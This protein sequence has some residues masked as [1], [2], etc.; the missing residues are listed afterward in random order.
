MAEEV[1]FDLG[2]RAGGAHRKAAAVRQVHKDHLFRGDGI[3]FHVYHVPLGK[4]ADAAD[5][6]AVQFR[7]RIGGVGRGEGRNFGGAVRTFHDQG[8]AHFQIDAE[9]FKELMQE[10]QQA[11]SGAFRIS[12]QFRK[13]DGGGVGILVA[14]EVLGQVAVAFLPAEYEVAAVLQAQGPRLLLAHPAVVPAFFRRDGFLIFSELL[15]NVFEPREHVDHF[16]PEV[17]ADGVLQPGGDE[18]FHHDG[19]GTVGVID[20]AEFRHAHAAVP[21]QQGADLVARQKVHFS[22]FPTH[23]HSHAV[24]IRVRGDDDVR[25]GSVRL[26]NG[27]GQCRRIFRV[28]GS[29]GREAAVLHVLRRHGLHVAAQ[30]FQQ[31]NDDVAARAVQVGV[32]DFGASFGEEFRTQKH[33]FQPVHVNAVEGG[34]QHVEFSPP[35]FRQGFVFF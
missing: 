35:V 3:A 31:R 10:F 32:N 30:F 27:H 8:F 20:D 2:F 5:G 6:D 29:H 13:D 19:A 16:I 14:H 34:V 1:V 23:G 28:R 4:V 24:R 12:G 7:G 18:C 22:V 9:F 26:F 17:V 25:S 33:G 11:F 21:R 15:G